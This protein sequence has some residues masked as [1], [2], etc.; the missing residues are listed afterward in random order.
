MIYPVGRDL[1]G[2]W[3]LLVIVV[4]VLVLFGTSGGLDGLVPL[5][6]LGGTLS[7]EPGGLV[8]I[9]ARLE[10]IIDV[11]PELLDNLAVL[12]GL[13]AEGFHFLAKL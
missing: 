2:G 3:F 5:E 10:E 8:D 6:E 13:E 7:G 12:L 1:L 9:L 11:A 4:V